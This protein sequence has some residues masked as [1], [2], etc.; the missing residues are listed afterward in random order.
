[1]DNSKAL[2]FITSE[3]Y[4][5]EL[6]NK[7]EANWEITGYGTLYESNKNGKISDDYGRIRDYRWYLLCLR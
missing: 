3:Y 7:I 2:I 5:T 6:V 4:H 1:M